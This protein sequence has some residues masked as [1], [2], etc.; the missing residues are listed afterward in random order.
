M[1]LRVVDQLIHGNGPVFNGG[2]RVEASTSPLWVA[3]LAL[4]AWL[5]GPSLPWKSV[6]LGIAMAALGLVAA[7]RAAILLARP[8]ARAGAGEEAAEEAAAPEGVT[9]SADP[10][11]PAAAP[12][13]VLPIGAV[14]LLGLRPFW[15]FATSGLETGLEF[16]WLGLCCWWTARRVTAPIPQRLRVEAA[17]AVLVGLGCLVRPDLAVFTVAFGAVLLAAVWPRGWRARI[18]W[19][20]AGAALPLAYQVFR[21]GYYAMIIPNTAVAKEAGHSNWAQGWTYLVD[22][23]TPY[24]L[25][26]PIGVALALVAAQAAGDIR[27]GERLRAAARLAPVA[28]A[29]LHS[30]YIVRVGGD[31]MHARLLLPDVFVLLA[32]VG[33]ALPRRGRPATATVA[34]GIALAAWALVSFLT[35]RVPYH[36]QS[37]LSSSPLPLRADGTIEDERAVTA[38]Y[39]RLDYPV[40]VDEYTL[41]RARRHH[42]LPVRG[43]LLGR[44]DVNLEDIRAP[45]RDDFPQDYAGT[46]A[47][48][49]YAWGPD[50]YTLDVGALGDPVGSHLYG[51]GGDRPAHQKPMPLAWQFAGRTSASQ[52]LGPDGEVVVSAREL[53]VTERALGCGQLGIYLEDVRAPLT[54]RRFVGN[55]LD[56]FANTSLRVPRDPDAAVEALCGEDDGG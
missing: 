20:A 50:A 16:G 19:L 1:H 22:L 36:V 42:T 21:M 13:L 32:P 31:F 4:A 54:P 6:L 33:L 38:F 35:L 2:E 40:E 29:L 46:L 45:L 28:G 9:T 51:L 10:A 7:Q 25:W 17:G 23:V 3:V 55:I 53:A 5:P 41:Y 15:E 44:S 43:E 34:A 37:P 56:S 24:V 14:A 47:A 49:A 11:G 26:L 39:I 48:P 12:A 18:V 27:A 30:L 8:A 52:V